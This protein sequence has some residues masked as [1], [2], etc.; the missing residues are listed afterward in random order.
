MHGENNNLSENEKFTR[1]VTRDCRNWGV[2]RK[3]ILV[4]KHTYGTHSCSYTKKIWV[5]LYIATMHT[6]LKKNFKAHGNYPSFEQI[7]INII[8]HS[9]QMTYLKNSSFSLLL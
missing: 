9:V 5:R 4:T 3:C 1:E 7:T 6:I 2:F 8:P